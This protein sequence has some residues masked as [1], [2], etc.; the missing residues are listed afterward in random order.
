VQEQQV[1]QRQQEQRRAPRLQRRQPRHWRHPTRLGGQQHAPAQADA[2]C[3]PERDHDEEGA[4]RAGAPRGR[5]GVVDPVHRHRYLNA[6]PRGQDDARCGQ[7]LAAGSPRRRERATGPQQR[8]HDKQEPPREAVG[9]TAACHA[10]DH[11]RGTAK[12]T[13]TSRLK[14]TSSMPKVLRSGSTTC[15]KA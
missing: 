9:Q 3:G 4:D 15:E 10:H 2:E 1:R 13:P 14:A 7:L 12:K 5:E 8:C 11:E 6:G